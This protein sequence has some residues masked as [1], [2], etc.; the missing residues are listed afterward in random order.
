MSL[1]FCLFGV[2]AILSSVSLPF[3][4]LSGIFVAVALPLKVSLS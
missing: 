1:A 2:P 3:C 4:L